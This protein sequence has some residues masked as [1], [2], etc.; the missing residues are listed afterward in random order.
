MLWARASSTSFLTGATVEAQRGRT[1]QLVFMRSSTSSAVVLGSTVAGLSSG[2]GGGLTCVHSLVMSIAA[3]GAAS[4]AIAASAASAAEELRFHG[5][6]L[7]SSKASPSLARRADALHRKSRAARPWRR[8]AP[9]CTLAPARSTANE[10]AR[11]RGER[12]RRREGGSH[13]TQGVRR[14]SRSRQSRSRRRLAAGGAGAADRHLEAQW[15]IPQ[16]RRSR[17]VRTKT[18][19]IAY[20]ESGPESGLPVLMMHGFPYDPRAYDG[21]VP[22]LVA[23]GCRAIVPY[24]RGYGPTQFLSA[25]DAALRPAGGA[26]PGSPRPHG[27]AA[28]SR[29]RC[30]SASTGAGAAPASSR[31][32]GRSGCAASSPPAATTSRTS[33]A[34]SSRRRRIASTGCGTS[35]ISTPSAAAP[36]LTKNR[37]ALCKLLWQLWSPTWKFDDA[38]YQRSAASFHNPDF[39]DVVIQSYRHRFGYAPGDP[40]LEGVEKRLAAHPPITVPTV[41][42]HGMDDGVAGRPNPAAQDAPSSPAASSTAC[43]RASA[44]TRPRRR[45]PRSSRRCSRSRRA[46]SSAGER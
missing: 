45:R 27:C 24:L 33:R 44:T 1:P 7:G 8:G 32:Y 35:I 29:P 23:A 12:R 28:A 46:R 41:A 11:R 40:D 19:E 3:T 22:P 25:A 2:T 30:S 42:M 36:G 26:R 39:V 13:A 31:R 18:L 17:R 38:T 20:E 4:A 16:N 15:P 10:F 6:S 9:G 34:R 21:M 37:D 5:S 14:Q 43:S